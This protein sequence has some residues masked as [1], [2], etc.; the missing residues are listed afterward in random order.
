MKRFYQ[1]LFTASLGIA[2]SGLVAATSVK[3]VVISNSV[4]ALGVNPVGSLV[5]TG[6]DIG[7]TFLPTDGEALAPGCACEAWGVADVTSGYTG[8]AGESNGNTPNLSVVSFS[9]T[10]TSAVSVVSV[11]GVFEVT[12]DFH[13]S[14][15]SNLF[16]V[17][18]TILNTT[19]VTVNPRYRRA[20]DWDVPPT[21]FDEY[22]TINRGSAANLLF[23]SDNGFATGNPLAGPSWVISNTV[24][25]SVVENGP[26]DH[27][28]VFD[29]GF[30]PLAP[31]S[32]ITF[33]IYYGAAAN[34]AQ[35]IAAV[36]RV[37]GEVFSFGQPSSPGGKSLGTPNTFIFAFQGVGGAPITNFGGCDTATGLIDQINGLS[38]L[39]SSQKRS[40]ARIANIVGRAADRSNF[41]GARKECGV[42][43]RRLAALVRR[44]T[45]DSLTAQSVAECCAG[46]A[47]APASVTVLLDTGE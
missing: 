18:V 42:I 40:L 27:G 25:K 19:N 6:A 1:K 46:L 21:E 11:G 26:A 33:N 29:F 35:A 30:A 5:D 15:S 10:A 12:H 8:S 4:V 17:T 13:P 44:G 41:Y 45:I 24:N 16:E 31:G 7:L 2:L 3:A 34:K 9:S 20:M 28:A 38:E 39:K 36:K 14:L 32:N 47:T 23:S 22:V 37:G 43:N